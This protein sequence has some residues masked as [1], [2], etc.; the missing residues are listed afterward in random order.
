[1]DCRSIFE[2][3]PDD[4]DYRIGSWVIITETDGIIGEAYATKFDALMAGLAMKLPNGFAVTWT[5]LTD[6]DTRDM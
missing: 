4:V 5:S 3:G 1:M 2:M 6:L